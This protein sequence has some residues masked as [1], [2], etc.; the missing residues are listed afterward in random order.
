MW[1]SP[2]TSGW[3]PS[4]ARV[5]MMLVNAEKAFAP[6]GFLDHWYT[7]RAIT[8]GRSARSARLLVGSMLGSERRRNRCPGHW[9]NP[10]HFVASSRRVLSGDGRGDDNPPLVLIAGP[11]RQSSLPLPD[12]MPA[13]A[14]SP[15][16]AVVSAGCRMPNT[17]SWLGLLRRFLTVCRVTP[18]GLR[19]MD[20]GMKDTPADLNWPKGAGASLIANGERCDAVPNSGSA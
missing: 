20:V 14:S 8:A 16:V 7:F 17:I 3:S 4:L 9:A 11:R 5:P 18:V 10:V 12:G 19:R 13:K 1:H 6:W 15:L 2:S